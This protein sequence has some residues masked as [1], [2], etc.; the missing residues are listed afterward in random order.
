[1]V[2]LAL[3]ASSEFGSIPIWWPYKNIACTWLVVLNTF[4]FSH[5]YIVMVVVMVDKHIVQFG[6]YKLEPPTRNWC[7]RC[8]EFGVCS[9]SGMV[10]AAGVPG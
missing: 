7:R 6:G 8:R 10:S 3:V 5:I 2:A 1:M 4:C 9:V